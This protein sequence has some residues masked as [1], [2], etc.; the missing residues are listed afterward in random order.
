MNELIAGKILSAIVYAVYA[1]FWIRFLMHALVWWRASRRL[2]PEMPAVYGSRLNV[3][4]LTMLDVT[5]LG[6]LFI[7]NPALWLGEW[8]FHA[9]FLLVLLRHLRFFLDPVPGWVWSMQMPG[10]IA[11]Y[12]LPMPLIYILAIR[13]LTKNE[14]YSSRANLLMLILMLVI[15]LLGLA[16]YLAFKPDLAGVK[17]FI[18]GI[19]SFAPQPAPQSLLFLAHFLFALVLVVLLP[20]HIFTAPL[21]LFEARK[22]EQELRGVMHEK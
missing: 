16:M 13:L 17:L 6:R 18:L 12:F 2:L 19:L 4:A 9:S 15:S 21:V 10:L 20:S 22:R 3:W 5:M 8:L 7:V 1:A 11:S 14:K